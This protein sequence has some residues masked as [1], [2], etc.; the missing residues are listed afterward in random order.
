MRI[1][2]DEQSRL[3]HVDKGAVTLTLALPRAQTRK[4]LEI[5]ADG[6]RAALENARVVVVNGEALP[7]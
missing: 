5:A 3:V 6:I 4:D 2:I 1:T 7:F